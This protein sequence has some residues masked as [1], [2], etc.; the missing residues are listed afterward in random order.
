MVFFSPD[1]EHVSRLREAEKEPEAHADRV[2]VVTGVQVGGT[3]FQMEGKQ[4]I[5][6]PAKCMAHAAQI[7]HTAA[8]WRD[9]TCYK[10]PMGSGITK[11]GTDSVLYWEN[12]PRPVIEDRADAA[13]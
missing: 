13:V 5:D 3:V 1:E 8:L 6:T 12:G 2:S 4:A 9:S 11:G 10:L 7:N